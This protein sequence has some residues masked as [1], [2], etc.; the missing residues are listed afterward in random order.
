[1]RSIRATDNL[2]EMIRIAMEL[3]NRL[4]QLEHD[5]LF[6]ASIPQFL[7]LA[8]YKFIIA[9][10]DRSDQPCA[11]G[12]LTFYK[13]PVI[14][15]IFLAVE[16]IWFRDENLE[17]QL[18]I[19]ADL[20]SYAEKLEF[21]AVC[22]AE[23]SVNTPVAL[24]RLE[25]CGAFGR[26]LGK[27]YGVE[28]GRPVL[29]GTA[30]GLY[31]AFSEDAQSGSAFFAP[32]IVVAP[33]VPVNWSGVPSQNAKPLYRG[34]GRLEVDGAWYCQDYPELIE[35][36][37][38]EGFPPREAKAG[39]SGTIPEQIL[40]QGYVNQGTVSLT[41][42]PEVAAMYAR[43]PE[44]KSGV[45]FTIDRAR[46]RS[47][48]EVYDSY[49][50]MHKY[51]D[52]FFESE[53]E[54][55]SKL[56]NTLGVLDGGNFLNRCDRES[57]ELVQSGMD[58]FTAPPA[59]PKYF[60]GDGWAKLRGA[61]I[62]EDQLTSLHQAFRAFWSYALGQ[63]GSVDTLV[64]NPAG[65]EPKVTTKAVEPLG[66]YWAFREVEEK[67]EDVRA[68]AAEEY[69]RNPGWQTTP[70][71]YVAKTCRDKEFFSTGS[72]PGDCIIDWKILT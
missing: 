71:G 52:W 66:Y 41:E 31:S 5:E 43:G 69:K 28:R 23:K 44:C 63:V 47:Y 57:R 33:L 49:A 9:E 45:V 48:G 22:V 18:W 20:V 8:G 37:L 67:L 12:L 10:D 26:E 7:S 54:T 70:F 1:M 19:W 15:S 38:K 64:L 35:H 65:G 2:A 13:A 25:K 62:L 50:S 34:E 56:V 46:L 32:C 6:A 51:L 55:L 4:P 29:Q 40:Q 61:G 17:D 72:V 58:A 39:F 59:W 3:R 11:F 36:F 24:G 16:A 68:T 60:E 30:P 27:K 21:A 53:F 14:K 42:S